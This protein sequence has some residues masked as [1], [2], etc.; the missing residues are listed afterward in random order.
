MHVAS[1]TRLIVMLGN[2][3][4]VASGTTI[5]LCA[6][7]SFKASSGPRV[8]PLARSMAFPIKNGPRM[9]RAVAVWCFT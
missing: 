1:Q 5:R 6:A 3:L 9:D 8:W 7:R 2:G 4:W